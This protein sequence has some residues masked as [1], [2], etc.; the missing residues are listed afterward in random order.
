MKQAK[1]ESIETASLILAVAIL[2]LVF[3]SA[4][5][6]QPDKPENRTIVPNIEIQSFIRGLISTNR[7]VMF[8]GTEQSLSERLNQLRTMAGQDKNLAMQLMYFSAHTKDERET[9]LPGF[10]LQQLAIS[11]AVFADVCLPLLNSEDEPT[12]R[13][14]SKWLTRAD[15]NSNGSVDFSRYED[16]VREKKQN[17]PQGL[18]R[19]M[20]NRNPQ[21]ALMSMSRVYGDTAAEAE[22]ADKLK[23]DPKD[24]LSTLAN[25]SEWWAHLY[26]AET[27]KKQPQLR[28]SAILKELEKD[29]DPLVKEKVAEITSGK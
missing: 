11:N 16:I 22:L 14:A 9:M 3:P 2:V 5:A 19:Y 7:Q 12:R 24:V 20:F 27:M 28:D 1:N 25:Q 8:E 21:A 10:I 26:V 4:F 13:L 23:G 29:D 15:Y 18:I 6:V 17:P